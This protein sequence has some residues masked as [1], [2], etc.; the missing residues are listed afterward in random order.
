MAVMDKKKKKGLVLHKFYH[1]SH[2][3]KLFVWTDCAC[4]QFI[5][6]DCQHISI[7]SSDYNRTHWQQEVCVCLKED[8]LTQYL[9]LQHP[10][11]PHCHH[12]SQN[13]HTEHTHKPLNVSLF[14]LEWNTCTT[15]APLYSLQSLST[16]PYLP[17]SRTSYHYSCHPVSPNFHSPPSFVLKVIWLKS[18]RGA[19]LIIEVTMRS[20]YFA[21]DE[22]VV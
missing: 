16:S 18:G 19:G 15:S 13:T 9:C 8:L 21:A 2:I 17:L 20:N 14:S 7:T 3:F 12:L 6:V 5:C 11:S 4:T 1:R 22:N 10:V